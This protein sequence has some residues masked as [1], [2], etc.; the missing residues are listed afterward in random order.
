MSVE[1]VKEYLRSFHSDD[2][3][4]EF[5]ASS[6]T[7]PLAAAALCYIARMILGIFF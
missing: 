2:R 4:M 5:T 1:S 3:V 6:A 7:V